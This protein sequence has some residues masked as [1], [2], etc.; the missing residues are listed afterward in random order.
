MRSTY[1][2]FGVVRLDVAAQTWHLVTN[3][4]YHAKL[5][6]DS[7]EGNAILPEIINN[8]TIFFDG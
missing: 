3:R 6:G 8:V 5:V 7:F 2:E 4:S 1:D